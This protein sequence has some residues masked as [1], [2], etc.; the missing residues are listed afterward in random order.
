M[1]ALDT[2]VLV[3]F[4]T[5]GDETQSQKVYNLFKSAE[6][7]KTQMFVPAVVLLELIWVLESAYEIPK[8]EVADALS[9][10]LLLPILIFEHQ[11]A[12][13]RFA[14]EAKTTNADLADLLIAHISIDCGCDKVLTFDKKAA[15]SLYFEL[16]K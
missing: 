16:V 7:E 3:R 5:G 12:V 4:M 8:K 11:N 2:N 1:K 14:H 13:Q 6:T 15:R 10:L 9:N